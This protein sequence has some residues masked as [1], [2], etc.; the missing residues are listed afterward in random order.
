MP[1][2]CP[3]RAEGGVVAPYPQCGIV[4]RSWGNFAKTGVSTSF[5]IFIIFLEGNMYFPMI[6]EMDS[7]RACTGARSTRA[8]GGYIAIWLYSVRAS[9][10]ASWLY[11]QLNVCNNFSGAPPCPLRRAFARC[12]LPLT[13]IDN[14]GCVWGVCAKC[15]FG[16]AHDARGQS[17]PPGQCPRRTQWQPRRKRR[18]TTRRPS[19]LS[20]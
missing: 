11:G 4:R 20:S 1:P 14:L 17:I 8:R 19:C 2:G 7:P 18:P 5:L 6:V 16:A 13:L 12:T 15:H 3:V 10:I 9:S